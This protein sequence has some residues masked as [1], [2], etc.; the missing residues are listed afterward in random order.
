M[1]HGTDHL[2]PIRRVP[3]TGELVTMRIAATKPFVEVGVISGIIHKLDLK[4]DRC[5]L[6]HEIGVTNRYIVFMDC[7]L[8]VD[9]NRFIRGGQLIKYESEGNTKIGI[10]PR[11]GDA[12]SIQWFKVGVWGCGALAS[13]IPGPDQGSKKLEWFPTKF[14]PG[15]GKPIEDAILED[16][17]LF[18]RPYEW[19]LNVQTGD[20]KQRNLTG[21]NHFPM[22]FP[23][24]NGAFTGLKNKYGY[25]QVGHCDSSPASGMG[26]FGGLAKVYFEEENNE[27]VSIKVDYH[28][29][30]KNTYCS[31][32]AFV[33]K[34]GG[35]EEDDGWI[36]TFVHHEDTSIPELSQT[37]SFGF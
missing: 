32:A 11:N 37:S 17:L 20:V 30:E 36:I 8:T 10:M 28:M 9:V 18:P 2:L 29:F 4:L 3:G 35:A 34:E 25:T 27:E 16:P 21:P 26:R 23:M 22:E 19:R 6:C 14:K 15:P 24:I 33:P 13:V 1:E 12:G 5:P 31:G 7:P